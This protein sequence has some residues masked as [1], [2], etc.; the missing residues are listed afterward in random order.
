MRFLLCFLLL[1]APVW[2]QNDTRA[3]AERIAVANE[4]Y[5]P[6][7]SKPVPSTT[8]RALFAYALVLCE[9]NRNME[10]LERLFDLAAQMQDRTEGSRSY[11]NFKWKW[12]DE[13]IV[14]FNAVD[15]SMRGGSLLWM[16]HRDK[17]P[18]PAL[19]KLRVLLEFS[20]EGLKRHRVSESYTNIALMNASDLIL[21][22]EAM[23]KP[24]YADEGY[25]RLERTLL[26]MSEFG[27][28]EYVSPTY[29][30]P[31]LDALVMI[32]AYAK[33]PRG[34]EQARALLN[35][36]WH[37]IA[38][39]WLP[40]AQKLSGANSRSYD[41]LRGL[42]E[43]DK[44]F[45]F[46]GWIE[47]NSTNLDYIYTVQARWKPPAELKK[48]SEQF[49]RLVQQKW[50]E[51]PAQWRTNYIQRDVALSTAGASYNGRMDFP[52]TVD[53]PGPRTGVR[54]YFT[55]DARND[56]YGR[57][58]IAESATHSKALH[59]NP[60]WSA[61]Q[62]NEK[63]FGLVLY[64]DADIPVGSESLES[65][66]V[67]PL[68]N[69]GLWINAQKIVFEKGKAASFSVSPTQS[70]FLRKGTA[71]LSVRVEWTR[72]LKGQA[73]PI[74]LVYDGN[75]YGAIRLTVTHYKGEKIGEAKQGEML[76]GAAFSLE[77]AS[78]VTDE[79]FAAFRRG[80]NTPLWTN[81][82]GKVPDSWRNQIQA[83]IKKQQNVGVL[84]LNGEDIGKKIFSQVE[85]VKSLVNRG[86][87]PEVRLPETGGV[88]WEAESGQIFGSFE[89][90]ND[91]LASGG[92][93]VWEPGEA[94]L[95][96]SGTGRALWKVTSWKVTSPQKREAFLWA[97]V[98][99]PTPDDDSFFLRVGE[100]EAQQW[101]LG[102]QTKWEWVR[103][104]EPLLI[105]GN[106]L[107]QLRT[108]ENG[109]KI[110]RF[111]L[112]RDAKDVPRD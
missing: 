103:H 42:G 18:A 65:H 52:L 30:G 77:V 33:R 23:E 6:D 93:F 25:K 70:V 105:N 80:V 59:L 71:V 108:R 82:T 19:E 49:P 24:A 107:L 61:W 16:K 90:E 79:K 28:H 37:D 53:F 4:R 101:P 62:S 104:K 96:G 2:A 12:D 95:G 43:A 76:A 60:F 75:N 44:H 84:T 8:S 40:G 32:E 111:F 34:V 17:I 97:R 66:F 10:R 1:A 87:A 64:R 15:F 86:D 81:F 91:A 29:Y 22:G 100:G 14:D 89:I 109:A 51:E 94:G 57:I 102:T 55:S 11:G 48:L 78:D 58:K 36:F 110:D 7:W 67:M 88:Y 9:A 69:D 20:L 35:F 13:K 46:N 38:L 47:G 74:N 54:C 3:V 85:P 56:P 39:N 27:T 92:K 112:T 72:D 26:Y 21:L 31:D 45:E 50:G 63:A 99:A 73:A 68:D 106:T 98:L 5:W 41:Y 83:A